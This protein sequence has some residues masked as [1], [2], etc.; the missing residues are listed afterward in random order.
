MLRGCARNEVHRQSGG[1]NP[2][3]E[4]D[5]VSTTDTRNPAFDTQQFHTN[6]PSQEWSVLDFLRVA[7]VGSKLVSGSYEPML[8]S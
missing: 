8:G 4:V 6:T 2:S 3:R 1:D 7:H 5:T